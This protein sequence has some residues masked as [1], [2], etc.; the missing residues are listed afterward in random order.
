MLEYMLELIFEKELV[1]A[2]QMYQKSVIFHYRIH[3][4]YMSKNDA[5]NI[6]ILIEM[7]KADCC[8]FFSLYIK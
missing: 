2:K 1:L 7:K 6:I 8:D 5:I 4:W 3:F